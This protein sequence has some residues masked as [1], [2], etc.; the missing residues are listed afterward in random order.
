MRDIE[1]YT[2]RGYYLQLM[3]VASHSKS[4][5]QLAEITKNIDPKRI[6]VIGGK[7]DQVMTLPSLLKLFERLGGEKGGHHQERAC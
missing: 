5:K 1:G 6:Q 2:L 7:I 4:S 3:A